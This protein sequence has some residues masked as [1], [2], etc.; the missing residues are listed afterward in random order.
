M[1]DL[2]RDVAEVAKTFVDFYPNSKLLTSSATVRLSFDKA[3]AIV[4]PNTV[5]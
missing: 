5:I 2:V 1:E 3:L 4:Q